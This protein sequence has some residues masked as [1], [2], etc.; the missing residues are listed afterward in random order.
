MRS[1]CGALVITRVI[2]KINVLVTKRLF[3]R[4]DR[5][6]TLRNQRVSL[7]VNNPSHNWEFM[8]NWES[9]IF[10]IQSDKSTLEYEKTRKKRPSG[11]PSGQSNNRRSGQSNGRVSKSNRDSKPRS[12]TSKSRSPGGGRSSPKG[13]QVTI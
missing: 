4:L 8:M 11:R 1:F 3:L 2:D 13:H 12:K 5:R 10:E 7:S 6:L 9:N